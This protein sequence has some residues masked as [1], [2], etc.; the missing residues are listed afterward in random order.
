MLEDYHKLQREGNSDLVPF[1]MIE[2]AGTFHQYL[3]CLCNN[4]CD[5]VRG[6]SHIITRFTETYKWLVPIEHAH[7]KV[8]Y[9]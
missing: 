9:G 8:M 4:N 2:L 5:G 7:D 6:I 3:N 1:S